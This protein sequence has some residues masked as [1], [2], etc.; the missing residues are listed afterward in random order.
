MVPCA[1]SAQLLTARFAGP[2]VRLL[3]WKEVNK[4][5]TQL[6]VEYTRGNQGKRSHRVNQLAR[7]SARAH[8]F[9]HNGRQ[10]SLVPE[11]TNTTRK[12]MNYGSNYVLLRPNQGNTT[13]LHSNSPLSRTN[14][15]H[16]VVVHL[17]PW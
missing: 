16:L 1:S 10:V 11:T 4:Q 12:L 15:T 14:L 9:E 3:Q 13:A 17:V 6:K 5:L 7:E 8:R 2:S